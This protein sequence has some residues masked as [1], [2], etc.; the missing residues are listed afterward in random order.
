[1]QAIALSGATKENSKLID[2]AIGR[3]LR[4][5]F[6]GTSSSETEEAKRMRQAR[7]MLAR[8]IKK[9]YLIRPYAGDAGDAAMRATE[10]VH[11]EFA[12]A[13]RKA[14]QIEH[15]QA[16]QRQ[17]R[18]S[19]SLSAAPSTAKRMTNLRDAAKEE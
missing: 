15:D 17:R 12:K 19:G 7:E 6:P 10:S 5:R 14:M 1:M 16:I 3:Y 9:V 4:M 8:E 18:S 13:A 2:Q 11:P